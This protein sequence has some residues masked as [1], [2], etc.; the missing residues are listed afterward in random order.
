MISFKRQSPPAGRGIQPVREA[1]QRLP[2]GPH[3]TGFR[4]LQSKS[5]DA[6]SDPQSLT[7]AIKH[8]RDDTVLACGK[9]ADWYGLAYEKCQWQIPRGTTNVLNHVS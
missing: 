3:S 5:L 4:V 9:F 7:T 6:E 8:F 2:A 1:C